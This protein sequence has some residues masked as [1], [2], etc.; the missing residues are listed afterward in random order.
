MSPRGENIAVV[1][2]GQMGC[3]IAYALAAAGHRVDLFDP[4]EGA[5]EAIPGRLA[6]IE[7]QLGERVV[8]R[9]HDSLAAAVAEADVVIEAGP[10]NLATKQAIFAELV[11]AAPVWALLATNTSAIPI[12]KIAAGLPTAGRVLGTHFWNPPHLIPLVEVVEAETTEAETVERMIGFLRGAGMRPVHVRADIPGFIGNRLQHAL[13]REA[14]AIVAAGHCDAEA[15]DE[16]VRHGFGARL[17]VLGPL[18]QS[19]L[20]GLELTLA[21]HE[22]L[23]PDLDRTPVAHPY[24]VEKVERGETGAATGRG[25]RAWAEGEADEVRARVT[26]ELL[27]RRAAERTS[28]N[29][30]MGTLDGVGNEKVRSDAQ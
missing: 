8:V 9:V 25:F 20:N 7:A 21:I 17:G 18:E 22:T 15:L 10:E 30:G 6:A 27:R 4:I 2:A 1:G 19:D 14:I 3:S 16:V 13:K 29:D 26:R 11:R 28:S 24:L 23:M 12:A 5:R